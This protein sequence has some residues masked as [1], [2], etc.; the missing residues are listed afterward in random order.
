ML[1]LLI[2]HGYVITME[3]PGVGMLEDGAIGIRG[4]LIEAV[5]PTEELLRK[6]RAQRVLDA[7]NMAV[8][9]GLIDA[10]IHT[11]ISLLRGISQ[12]I[13][14]WMVDGLW[15][16]ETKLRMDPASSMKGTRLNIVESVKA[17]T[18]TFC[19]FDSPM[20]RLVENHAKLGTRARVAELI[21]GLPEN[22]AGVR[23]DEPFPLSLETEKIKLK[24]NLRLISNWNGAE[25]GRIT[26]M[27]GPQAAD[28]VTLDSLREIKKLSEKLGV[29]LHMHV[30][31]S[32]H[33]NE[34]TMLK[35]GKRAIPFLQEI[36][37]LDESLMAVHLVDATTDEVHTLAKSRAGMVACNSGSAMLGGCIPPSYEFLEVSDRLA[38]G[39]D[40]ATGNNC[41]NMFNEMKFTALL[42]KCKF[43]SYTAFPAW[44]VLRMATVD[45]AKAIGLGDEIGSIKEGKKA[46][47]I[48]ID[49]KTPT[50]TPVV[51]E[52]VRNIVPNLVYSARGDEVK[53]VI[54]DGKIVME[55]RVLKT[56]DERIIIEEAQEA[57]E[58]ICREA[59]PEF[60]VRKTALYEMMRDGK[61]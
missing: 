4:N 1:D 33:E 21:S 12:D 52:P 23:A 11:S 16:F 59:A 53:T 45:G 24:R 41:C 34:Q 25:N 36:G 10:H 17:G 5:G 55:D 26:C 47:V 15:P 57:A 28:M 13:D 35:Y 44:K 50:M 40:E 58:R 60:C 32:P 19:D 56:V 37:Y 31:Q 42:N 43:H 20:D 54:I 49:L 3:G 48:L 14:N 27:L 51:T 9:P 6:Y 7:H 39:S 18:T 30:S 61:L 38:I 2:I 22:N 8:M 29:G 46:D